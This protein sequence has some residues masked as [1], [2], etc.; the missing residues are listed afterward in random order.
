[1]RLFSSFARQCEESCRPEWT[2]RRYLNILASRVRLVAEDVTAKV[3]QQ[4]E[5]VR[6][7]NGLFCTVSLQKWVAT[8][9]KPALLITCVRVI[10]LSSD[11]QCVILTGGTMKANTFKATRPCG[12]LQAAAW[13]HVTTR[14]HVQTCNGNVFFFLSPDVRSTSY[15]DQAGVW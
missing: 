2:A 5:Q 15:V 13:A 1:V 6:L 4:Q 10:L 11:A 12:I 8:G 7:Q 3:K 9:T 14:T